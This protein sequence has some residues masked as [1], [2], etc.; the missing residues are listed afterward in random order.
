M[1]RGSGSV[2]LMAKAPGYED[3][4]ISLKSKIN[5]VAF[6][7]LLAIYSWTTDGV[8][9]GAWKYKQDGVYFNMERRGMRYAEAEK[10]KKDTAI[11]RFVLFGY[12]E[13]KIEAASNESGEYIKAL[14]E[15]S[16]QD[17]KTLIKKINETDG[18]VNLAHYM[19]D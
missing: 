7:N 12:P 16:A 11:R 5:P 8:T 19:V 1:E 14:A 6:G 4:T 2:A 10:H 15:L 13:L 18:E 9:G 17:E 3:T